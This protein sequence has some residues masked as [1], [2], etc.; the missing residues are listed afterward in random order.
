[1]AWK[2]IYQSSVLVMSKFSCLSFI[3]FLNS[4]RNFC[5]YLIWSFSGSWLITVSV[6]AVKTSARVAESL[7]NGSTSIWILLF[8]SLSRPKAMNSFEYVKSI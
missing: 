2:I 5:S 4:L 1:M 7:V 3:A 8:S 6:I